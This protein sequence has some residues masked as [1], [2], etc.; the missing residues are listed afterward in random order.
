M[1][2]VEAAEAAVRAYRELSNGDA[3]GSAEL[4]YWLRELAARRWE[5]GEAERAVEALT[6]SV[7]GYRVHAS[8][9]PGMLPVLASALTD[10]AYMRYRSDHDAAQAAEEAV[11]VYAELGEPYRLALALALNNLSNCST[12][13]AALATQRRAADVVRPLAPEHPSQAAMVLRNLAIC[14]REAGQEQEADAVDAE[15]RALG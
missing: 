2:D 1:D 9:D 14:L 8:R 10:L 15:A 5:R 12:G 11:T 4:T 13:A 6:E 7:A 3:G